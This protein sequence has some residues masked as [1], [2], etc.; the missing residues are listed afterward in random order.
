MN[1]DEQLRLMWG[2]VKADD[3]VV[4]VRAL[5]C[6]G[7][8]A[9]WDG[10]ATSIVSGYFDDGDAFVAAARALDESGAPS[11]IYATLNPVAPD[12]LA[13]AANRLI[14]VR[15][16]ESTTDDAHIVRRRWLLLDF[17]PARPAGISA[18]KQELTAALAAARRTRTV[19]AER[20]WPLPVLACS[21]NGWHLLYRY[22]RPNDDAATA[23]TRA[24]LGSLA[25]EFGDA[26]VGVDTGVYNASRIVKLYGTVARKG[27]ST[28]QRPH[29]RAGIMEMVP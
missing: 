27:D 12:L 11:G 21:G 20:G 1:R 9:A 6:N 19:L 5:D 10:F 15:R 24:L 25:T 8:H 16:K 2:L 26:A 14:A 29:R 23:F 7:K 13:R 4:E 18:T 17:D 22:D 28:P 3:G